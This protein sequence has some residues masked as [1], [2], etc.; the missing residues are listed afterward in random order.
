MSAA[1]LERRGSRR[2][3]VTIP[4]RACCRKSAL[5]DRY[6]EILNISETGA[7]FVTWSRFKE[8]DV[9]D[10]FRKIETRDWTQSLEWRHSAHVLRVNCLN[11]RSV[12]YGVAVRFD[13]VPG[14]SRLQPTHKHGAQ[15]PKA[16]A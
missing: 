1:D 11:S 13:G 4:I 8:G 16:V 5:P 3:T 12:T 10:L 15:D 14:L 2:L 7:Y 9:L 6:G